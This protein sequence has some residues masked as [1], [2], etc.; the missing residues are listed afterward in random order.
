M[1]FSRRKRHTSTRGV[2]LPQF[3]EMV[4]V[5]REY[6]MIRPQLFARRSLSLR[7]T[8]AR[9]LIALVL[10]VSCGAAMAQSGRRSPNSSKPS[11][12][13]ATAATPEPSGESESQPR[14]KTSKTEGPPPLTF[15]VCEF[16]NQFLNVAYIS[17]S[18]IVDAFA[19]RL[20]ESKGIAIV[21]GPKMSRQD[22]RARAKN[23]KDAFVVLVVL[24]EESASL[25][26]D[27]IA[28]EVSPRSL[29]MR[30]FVY[31]PQTA[32][33][34]FQDLV[35]QRPY[36]PTTTIGGVRVPLPTT[37]SAIPGQNELEQLARDAANR[38]AARFNVRLPPEN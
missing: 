10:S 31:A 35:M 25:G 22:A 29:I 6:F 11:D 1:R 3:F 8:P 7:S 26:R 30:Y 19:A 32:D 2:Q 16:D 24:E 21:R 5:R 4:I 36:R 15:V 23:E 33:L 9:F 37:R 18:Q 38:L 14:G 27:T 17:P 13:P 28:G 20:G 12:A 34:K